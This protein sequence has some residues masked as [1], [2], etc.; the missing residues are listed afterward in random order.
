MAYHI[1]AE[2]ISLEDLKLRIEATDLVPSRVSLREGLGPK[3]DILK[4][5][6]LGHLADLRDAI[7]TP[8]RID[9]LSQA[10]GIDR[11]YLVL[12]RREVNSY[13][14]KPFPLESFDWLSRDEIK[15]LEKAGIKDTAQF[16]DRCNEGP[17]TQS[18][19]KDR[20]PIQEETL[21]ALSGLCDLV[22]IQW[23]NPTL[24]R[25]FFEAGYTSVQKIAKAAPE[26]LCDA[27]Q[28]IN[29][30]ETY[31]RGNIGLRDIKRLIHSARCLMAGLERTADR[32]PCAKR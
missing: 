27:V 25:L 22:R 28:R 7:R 8:K 13:F 5:H 23:T 20:L 10:T 6:G 32:R 18:P 30:R 11:D 17:K 31:F 19:P 2:K 9:S 3:L 12:L 14:P 1:D 21:R 24:A 16:H 15:K 26:P 29:Q 4:E